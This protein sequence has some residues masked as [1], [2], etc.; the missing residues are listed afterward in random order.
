LSLLSLHDALPIYRAISPV[1]DLHIQPA[2]GG[3][4]VSVVHTSFGTVAKLESSDVNTPRIET[5]II[6]FD[7]Q[8]KIEFI[9]QIRK[10]KTF[11]KEGVYFAFPLA[12]E[13]PR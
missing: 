1:P 12:M 3:K 2:G 10:E 9:N 7:T 5:R 4:L 8:K 11:S 13:H 6:L